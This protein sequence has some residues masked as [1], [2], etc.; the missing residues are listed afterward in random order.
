MKEILILE[1]QQKLEK[2]GYPTP[3]AIAKE[4]V[5]FSQGDKERINRILI[6]MKRDEPWEYIKGYTYFKNN[7]ILLNHNVLIPR[8]ETEELVNL[9]IK[10]IGRDDQIIDIGTGSGCIAIAISKHFPKKKIWATDISK[11][12]L[13]IAR[14][15]IKNNKCKN[16]TLKKANLLNF[17]FNTKKSTVIIANLPYLKT[18]SIND[19]ETSVKKYE[20]ILAL[21]G[22]KLG[23]NLYEK[24][25]EQI[26]KREINFKHLIFEIDPQIAQYFKTKKFLIIK[27][28]FN[29]ERFVLANPSQLV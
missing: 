18:K 24:L 19:L 20:P 16:I 28:S 26:K 27:D 1:L 5:D 25:L 21:D 14:Q 15:N 23:Y 12:A 6:R 13:E 22:G 7:K 9:A 8:I 2:I 10:R 4:I 29:R 17:K 3:L 11:K